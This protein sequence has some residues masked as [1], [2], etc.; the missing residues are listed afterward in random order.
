MSSPLEDARDRLATLEELAD[1]IGA[2]R[3]IAASRVAR[4]RSAIAPARAYARTV[5][6]A[7]AAALARL[8]DGSTGAAGGDEAR[9][10][11]GAPELLVVVCS[12]QGFVGAF[13]EALVE[14]CA[15]QAGDGG[16]FV[17]PIVVGRR[18]QLALALR[19]PFRYEAL[20]MVTRAEA[21]PALATAL[22]ERIGERLGRGDCDR[23]TLLHR[24]PGGHEAL[25]RALL[26]LERHRFEPPRSGPPPL[27]DAA[28]ER[29]LERLAVE[30]LF[31]EL[32]ETLT[33]AHAAENDARARAM[34]RARMNLERLVEEGRAGYRRLH[35][36]GITAEIAELANG[37]RAVR[38]S[39]PS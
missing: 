31:A 7:V 17:P 5:G 38:R 22:V 16:T 21:V 32:C 23:V 3:A 27:G 1:V 34:E 19:E 36:A 13:N 28:P 14:R 10:V 4:A 12:E 26:P 9:V 8:P 18:G 29:L 20:P 39:S 2:M 6:A 24:R 35:Q 11:R 37:R 15:A 25:E 33:L 30:Y